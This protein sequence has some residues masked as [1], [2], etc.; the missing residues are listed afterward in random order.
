MT[1]AAIGVRATR[2]VSLRRR[3]GAVLF[4]AVALFGVVG[5]LLID[6]DPARQ[7]LSQTLAP[8]GGD[9]L[10]GADHLGRSVLAR[11][12]H[13]A[14]LSLSLALLTALSAAIPG[15]LLGMI[16]AWR[17]GRSDR[18]L[19]ALADGVLALPGLL[20]VLLLTA[21]APGAFWP[22]YLGLSL[23]L[24]VEYFR[25]VRAACRP[26]LAGPQVEA[27]RLLGFGLVHVV[28]RHI[29]P[30]IAP[31]LGALTAFGMA[32]AVMAVG[33]LS[34][35]GIGLRP[36]TAEWGIMLTEM[37]PYYDEAPLLLLLPATML[38]AAVLGLQ[39]LSGRDPR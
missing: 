3:V 35:V 15:T 30:E 8:I 18:A 29:L 7:N 27:A 22:L 34:F 1:A 2:G 20:L 36:P 12:A 38:F 6:A 17:G 37:M 32:A 19:S 4:G 33:S 39:L 13:A 9:Y 26:L 31:L 5:P 21:L 25:V 28:R 23:L 10:L 11:L 24:W 14:R 16:A